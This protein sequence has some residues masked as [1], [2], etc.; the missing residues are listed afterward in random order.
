MF[1]SFVVVFLFSLLSLSLTNCKKGGASSGNLEFSNDT[2]LFDT[3]FTTLGNATQNIRIYNPDGNRLTIDEIEL[4]GGANSPFSINVDG[5]SSTFIENIH[6]NGKDSLFIFAQVTLD[7]N[8]QNLPLI[9]EDSIRFRTNGIDQ[10]VKLLV[11]GQDAYFHVDELVSGVW[12][13]DKP[14]IIYGTAAVGYPG[15]DS[16]QTLTINAGTQVY[17]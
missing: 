17:F 13:P 15:L 3:V 7:V 11:W 9:V 1:R 5:N 12:N 2:I 8:N 6:V 14:H 16:N 10:Y 4:M